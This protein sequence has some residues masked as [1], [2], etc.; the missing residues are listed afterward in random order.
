MRNT[1]DSHLRQ[2]GKCGSPFSN[3]LLQGAEQ[4]ITCP[5][6]GARA[7]IRFFPAAVSLSSSAPGKGTSAPGENPC[8]THPQRK[9]ERICDGCGRFMCSLC[10]FAIG[11]RHLCSNCVSALAEQNDEK[12]GDDNLVSRRIQYDSIAFMLAVGFP[13]LFG[14]FCFPL[15][16]VTAPVSLWLTVRHWNTPC[17]LFPRNRWRFVV[18]AIVSG[19]SLAGLVGLIAFYSIELWKAF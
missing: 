14:C 5:A 15:L 18:A 11:D 10:D 19:A 1:V 16:L 8:Y 17:S 9:A 13:L 6:C 4:G 3:T 7:V 2:C 12:T